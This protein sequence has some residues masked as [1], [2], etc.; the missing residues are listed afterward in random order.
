[1][2]SAS[3]C[4]LPFVLHPPCFT[5]FS[6]YAFYIFS[7]H[8]LIPCFLPLGISS[9]SRECEHP[10][11]YRGTLLIKTIVITMFI[12]T[13]RKRVHNR[14]LLSHRKACENVCPY[15]CV[16]RAQCPVVTTTFVWFPQARQLSR[17]APRHASVICPGCRLL[18]V[19]EGRC[20]PA[21]FVAPLVA[22]FV[23][24][25]RSD[26]KTKAQALRFYR[27]VSPNIKSVARKLVTWLSFVTIF[28]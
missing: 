13:K 7:S 20:A 23:A 18:A 2:T 12:H 16:Y 15:P 21:I 6:C 27:Q 8:L 28:S 24:R 26:E 5:F 3:S 22:C 17:D 25:V 1:M 14:V 19:V 4:G 11:F 9:G 10:R